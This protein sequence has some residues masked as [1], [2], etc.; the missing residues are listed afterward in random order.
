MV[1][2]EVSGA[3]YCRLTE[4]LF[5]PDFL[6]RSVGGAGEQA[7]ITKRLR[8][9]W[10]QEKPQIAVETLCGSSPFVIDFAIY[11][12]VNRLYADGVVGRQLALSL[13]APKDTPEAQLRQILKR[14]KTIGNRLGLLPADA[15]IRREATE[16]FAVTA[17]VTGEPLLDE[18][19]F[20]SSAQ[21][22][23]RIVMTGF[24]GAEGTLQLYAEERKELSSLPA[25]FKSGV[26]K[27]W[28]TL[29]QTNA[30]RIARKNGAAFFSVYGDGGVFRGLWD[31]GERL[32]LGMRVSLP[33]IPLLQQTVEA[34]ERLDRNPYQM[35]G[36]GS[37][38]IVTADAKRLLDALWDAGVMAAEIGKLTKD[39]ARILKNQEEQRYL[40]PFR[41]DALAI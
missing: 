14:A 13:L 3:E 20:F 24:A 7:D 1:L 25:H 28:K 37:A 12:A 33:D 21:E 27:L 39:A 4:K 41:A 2:G 36:G 34:C 26:E 11:R 23:Y 19:A 17:A 30:M 8:L 22:D 9:F 29:D 38:L 16:Q 5:G 15:A 6:R 10:A 32:R 40:E 31:L 18:E 35:R